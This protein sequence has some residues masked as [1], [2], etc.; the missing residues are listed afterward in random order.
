[1]SSRIECNANAMR[2]Q[3]NDNHIKHPLTSSY[4]PPRSIFAGKCIRKAV[5][6]HSHSDQ[7]AIFSRPQ[8]SIAK[9][10]A[11]PPILCLSSLK[12][13]V[14]VKHSPSLLF[15]LLRW[16]FAGQ[17]ICRAVAPKSW[18]RCSRPTR[19][20][21]NAV[22]D[23]RVHHLMSSLYCLTWSVHEDVQRTDGK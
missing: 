19:E 16:M 3:W 22:N 8:K 17:C 14:Y 11:L 7:I 9:I 6:P 21:K 10:S 15:R 2:M 20:L 4:C 13:A 1:M 12:D 5:G 23:D 18:S